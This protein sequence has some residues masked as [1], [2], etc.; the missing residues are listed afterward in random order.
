MWVPALALGLF[1]LVV[2]YN[3][4]TKAIVTNEGFLEYI[5]YRPADGFF[6]RP[7]WRHRWHCPPHHPLCR[8]WAY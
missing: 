3:T 6:Y 1:L 2:A 4:E 5:V 8:R 7:W